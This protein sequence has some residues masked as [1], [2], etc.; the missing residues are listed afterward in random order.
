MLGSISINPLRRGKGGGKRTR[1]QGAV[2]RTGS[3]AFALHLDHIGDIAPDI[4]M[5]FEAHS[6]ASSAMVEEGVMG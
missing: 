3:A 4:L 6:S 2:H 1:L 5:P